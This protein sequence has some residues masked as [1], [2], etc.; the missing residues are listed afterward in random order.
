MNDDINDFDKLSAMY[1]LID[2]ITQ[3]MESRGFDALAEE[4][5]CWDCVDDDDIQ[6]LRFIYRLYTLNKEH[7]T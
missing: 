5:F 6:C 3:W 7:S 1:D 2:E 4:P